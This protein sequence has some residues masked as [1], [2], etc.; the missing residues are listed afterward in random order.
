MSTATPIIPGPSPSGKTDQVWGLPVSVAIKNAAG[1]IVA[2]L[3]APAHLY[4][5][6]SAQVNAP[7]GVATGEVIFDTEK[8][9]AAAIALAGVGGTWEARVWPGASGDQRCDCDLVDMGPAV[10]T[11]QTA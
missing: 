2:I 9:T 8:A 10:S 11:I 3:S 7:P 5:P 1:V 4:G 6:S